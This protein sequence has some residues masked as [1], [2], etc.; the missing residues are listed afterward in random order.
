MSGWGS[1]LPGATARI[2]GLLHLAEQAAQHG[3]LSAPVSASAVKAAVEIAR[4]AIAHARAAYGQMGADAAVLD[5]RRALSWIERERR[6]FVTAQVAFQAL[7]PTMGTMERTRAALRVLVDH[8]ALRELPEPD[9]RRGPG[10]PVSTR[11]EVNPHLLP[12]SLKPPKP[13]E[14]DPSLNF[15]DSG[16]F[17]AGGRGAPE[18]APEPE[19]HIEEPPPPDPWAL[20]GACPPDEAPPP[21]EPWIGEDRD[22]PPFE[23]YAGHQEERDHD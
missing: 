2:A 5:A 19:P 17:G 7:K 16:D 21:D 9:G 11:Y 4:W 18:R 23:V 22:D 1:K 20:G 6:P 10:R 13:P 15:G 14:S 8:N 3:S 12:P